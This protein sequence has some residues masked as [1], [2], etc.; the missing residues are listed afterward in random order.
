MDIEY[1][2]MLDI[3]RKFDGI[4][5]LLLLLLSLP[6]SDFSIKSS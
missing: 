3:E 1:S 5:Y 6:L 2:K 4:S